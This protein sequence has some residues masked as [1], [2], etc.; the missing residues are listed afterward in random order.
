MRKRKKGAVKEVWGGGR[1]GEVEE[2][3]DKNGLEEKD[4]K[5]EKVAW[6]KGGG[7]EREGERK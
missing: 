1:Q 5:E 3:L 7:R 4:E 2:V 6:Y